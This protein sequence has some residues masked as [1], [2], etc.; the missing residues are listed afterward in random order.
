MGKA[1]RRRNIRRKVR[2]AHLAREDAGRFEMAVEIRLQSWLRE[3]HRLARIWEEGGA[4][5]QNRVFG[6]LDTAMEV[7]QQHEGLSSRFVR[8]VQGVIEHECTV[9]VARIVD[10]RL[11]RLSN[12]DTLPYT[13]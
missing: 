3:I 13:R 4:E 2:L 6:I 9:Q 8:E 5:S 10:R 12:M 1:S 11:C 7:L